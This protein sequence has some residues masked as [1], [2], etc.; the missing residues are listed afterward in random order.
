MTY[1]E[2]VWLSMVYGTICMH[3]A[4]IRTQGVESSRNPDPV[5]Q[6]RVWLCE[7]HRDLQPVEKHG[8]ERNLE[9]GC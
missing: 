4:G 9:F 7:P 2:G 6:N 3:V 8:F 5:P 1:I